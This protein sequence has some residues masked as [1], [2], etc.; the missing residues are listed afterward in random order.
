MEMGKVFKTEEGKNDVIKFYD[1]FLQK[2]PLSYEKFYVNTRYGKMFI[3]ASG[4]KS[5][6]KQKGSGI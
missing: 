6:D 4:E 3:I 1:Q 5:K 2:L